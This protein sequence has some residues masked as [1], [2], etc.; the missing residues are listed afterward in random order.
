MLD[1]SNDCSYTFPFE[2]FLDNELNL[3][4][5]EF[6]NVITPNGDGNNDEFLVNAL[7]DNCVSYS[8]EFLNRWGELVFTMTSN[9]APFSGADLSGNLLQDGVYFYRFISDSINYRQWL[10]ACA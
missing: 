8:I 7:L 10:F 5:I 3:D 9:S 2:Y 6:P 1:L 4:N